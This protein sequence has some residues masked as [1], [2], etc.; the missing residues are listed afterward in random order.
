ML[1]RASTF[2]LQPSLLLFDLPLFTCEHVLR[3][4]PLEQEVQQMLLLRFE[5]RE[6]LLGAFQVFLD[7]RGPLLRVLADVVSDALANLLIQAHRAVVLDEL[8]VDFVH[9]V[10]AAVA[11]AAAAARPPIDAREVLV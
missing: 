4:E 8:S 3:D 2:T 7:Q 5:F 10:V 9:E 1:L 6:G 11:E